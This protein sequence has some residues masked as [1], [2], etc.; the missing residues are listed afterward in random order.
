M[1]PTTFFTL[2]SL[3]DDCQQIFALLPSFSTALRLF[4][5]F[6]RSSAESMES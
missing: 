2:A 5:A 1:T 4:W 3:G 6:S